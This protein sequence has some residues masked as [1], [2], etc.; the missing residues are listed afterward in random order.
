MNGVEYEG[1]CA[2]TGDF[3]GVKRVL[4]CVFRH[5]INAFFFV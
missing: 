4:K 5:T 3:K 1:F 2:A